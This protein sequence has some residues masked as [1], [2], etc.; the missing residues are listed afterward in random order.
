MSV[1]FMEAPERSPGRIAIGL[2]SP[3]PPPAA[4]AQGSNRLIHILRVQSSVPWVPQWG[5]SRLVATHI[6]GR[7][8]LE[9]P[10]R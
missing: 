8:A 7:L 10:P 3:P 5:Q 2:Y 6:A 9:P 1:R 4:F